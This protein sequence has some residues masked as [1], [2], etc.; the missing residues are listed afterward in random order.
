MID[1]LYIFL[2]SCHVLYP[3]AAVFLGSFQGCWRY[4]WL[5]CKV[6]E[7][8]QTISTGQL[9]WECQPGVSQVWQPAVSCCCLSQVV[10]SNIWT[11]EKP[12]S[13]WNFQVCFNV[14]VYGKT[15]IMTSFSTYLHP[16]VMF[17]KLNQCITCDAWCQQ[18]DKIMHWLV[19][20]SPTHARPTRA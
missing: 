7:G 2:Y 12:Q 20:L 6:Q 18:R 1:E 17:Q 8:A 9:F 16:E 15:G 3:N 14:T 19:S 5:D 4:S 11:E 10:S 13:R